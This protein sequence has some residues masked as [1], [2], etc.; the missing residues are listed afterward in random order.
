MEALKKSLAEK[1]APPPAA[2]APALAA[3]APVG[4][5]PPARAVQPIS[6]VQ[7]RAGKKI[8]G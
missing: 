5:K 6:S 7:K 2:A 1:Q 4:K 3:E 8:A